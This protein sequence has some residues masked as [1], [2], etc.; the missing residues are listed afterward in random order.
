MPN[1][2]TASPTEYSRF[3]FRSKTEAIFA[4]GLDLLEC[5]W[6]YE[7]AIPG[8]NE[9]AQWSNDV[10][11]P[12]FW[13]AIPNAIRLCSATRPANCVLAEIKPRR[14]TQTYVHSRFVKYFRSYPLPVGIPTLGAII[15]GLWEERPTIWAWTHDGPVEGAN[16]EAI[17][18]LCGDLASVLQ[19]AKAYRFD[20]EEE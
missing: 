8:L 2:L 19:D 9:A 6:E 4:R 13:F 12:D 18:R 17:D 1:L 14:P 3:V 16:S 7:P 11:R 15:F 10:W 5:S 20:L